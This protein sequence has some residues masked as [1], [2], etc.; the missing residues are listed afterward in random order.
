MAGHTRPHA[1]P[2]RPRGSV[3]LQI[4]E[5]TYNTNRNRHIPSIEEHRFAEEITPIPDIPTPPPPAGFDTGYYLRGSVQCEQCRINEEQSC[6]II[7]WIIAIMLIFIVGVLVFAP[8][9]HLFL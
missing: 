6:S 1:V 8:L 4:D 7:C 9:L 2:G 5:V 3:S